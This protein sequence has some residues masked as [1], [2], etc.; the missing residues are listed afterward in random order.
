ME[1]LIFII[2]IFA[3]VFLVFY[4][5]DRIGKHALKEECKREREEDE[6][7]HAL[8]EKQYGII[9]ERF[10]RDNFH[11]WVYNN[12]KKVIIYSYNFEKRCIFSFNEILGC[13]LSSSENLSVI[14]AK[15]ETTLTT[16]TNGKSMVGRALA[17]AI[18]AGPIGAVIG[19]ATANKNTIG[20]TTTT[21]ERKIT[22]TIN[23]ATIRVMKDGVVDSIS[24]Y[25]YGA[26]KLKTIIDNIKNTS[27]GAS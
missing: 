19:G 1:L 12:T 6:Q 25:G 18:I 8:L 15:N 27:N 22:K 11:V 23:C 21:P 5:Q 13:D 4:I 3:L 10:D 26:A 9:G 17:G 24:Y 20:V 2:A 14:P 7:K 16:K